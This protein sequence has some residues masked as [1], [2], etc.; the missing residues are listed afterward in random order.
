MVDK[1]HFAKY[2]AISQAIDNLV[3]LQYSTSPPI[4]TTIRSPA[5]P[6]SKIDSPGPYTFKLSASV[7][8]VRAI[9][10]LTS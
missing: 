2:L 6:S 1:R 4:T 3:L 7:N 9:V 5:W 8:I 10:L